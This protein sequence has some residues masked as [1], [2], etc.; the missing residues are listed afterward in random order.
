MTGHRETGR[1]ETGCKQ[2]G[3]NETVRK[4]TGGETTGVKETRTKVM[5]VRELGGKA[6][7]MKVSGWKVTLAQDSQ[8]TGGKGDR[9]MGEREIDN[10]LPGDKTA[11]Q[12][13]SEGIQQKSFSEVI[14]VVRKKA[15]VFVGTR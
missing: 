9:L 12:N 11:G 2:M 5:G 13:E 14:E 10:S 1:K 7:G 8:E 15:S 3:R 4:E 6:K